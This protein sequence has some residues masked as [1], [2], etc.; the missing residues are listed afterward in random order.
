MSKWKIYILLIFI[1]FGMAGCAGEKGAKAVVISDMKYEDVLQ[2][3]LEAE[4]PSKKEEQGGEIN[5]LDVGKA[6]RL[7]K[8]LAEEYYESYDEIV[9]IDG[10]NKISKLKYPI[11]DQVMLIGSAQGDNF[12]GFKIDYSWE[13]DN[14]QYSVQI[15]NGEGEIVRK[16]ALDYLN[17]PEFIFP[18]AVIEDVNNN[19][20]VAWEDHY[21]VVSDGEQVLSCEIPENFCFYRFLPLPGGEIALDLIS[22]DQEDGWVSHINHRITELNRNDEKAC[23]IEYDELDERL[24]KICSVNRFDDNQIVAADMEGLYLSDFSFKKIYQIYD[25]KD[26]NISVSN[27][28]NIAA[29]E[30][31]TIYALIESEKGTRYIVFHSEDKK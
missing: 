16:K 18:V 20:V 8:H 26:H 15:C 7:K 27:I 21:D 19:I 6:Y 23:I 3:D 10:K 28:Y 2:C 17:S 5:C 31:G 12:L 13:E 30:N 1:L 11:E 4:R 14:Y 24:D 29:D 22:F 25:W 9:M